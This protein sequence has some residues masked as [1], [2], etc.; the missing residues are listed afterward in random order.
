VIANQRTSMSSYPGM[1]F[2]SDDFYVLDSGLVLLETT[3]NILNEKLYSLSDPRSTVMAW[4]RNVIANRLASTG[5]EWSAVFA[6]Y[7]SGTYN[8]Q[9]MIVDYKRFTP[10]ASKLAPGTLTLFEQIPGFTK[11]ADVTP[12]LQKDK[13]WAS[14]NRPFFA[15]TNERS[16]FE[17]FA[18]AEGATKAEKEMFTYHQCP[19]AQLF[20]READDIDSLDDLKE[21]LRLNRYD[22]DP[23]SA[24]C[25][26]NAIAARYDLKPKPG[27]KCDVTAAKANG[28][29]DAKVTNAALAARMQAYAVAGPTDDDCDEFVW[30]KTKFVKP[31][32]Q[33]D[34]FNFD[35]KLMAFAAD[36]TT[37]TPATAKKM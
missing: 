14:Y 16:M 19:R 29:T 23:I 34:R 22:M 30:S 31:P 18:T 24:G 15:E 12:I 8:N 25:P 4:I 17:H 35:W 9:W 20:R 26:G 36:A 1:I 37:A 27:S 32:G 28:A 11:S 3:L 21:V 33:P 7:N 6:H 5:D 13:Y 10:N 2:S